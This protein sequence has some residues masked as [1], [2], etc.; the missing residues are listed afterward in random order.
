MEIFSIISK[1]PINADKKLKLFAF[2][3]RVV[4]FFK[5][6]KQTYRFFVKNQ[7]FAN[8]NHYYGH[9]YWLK[10]YSG[11]TDKIYAMIEHGVY[12]GD[13]RSLVCP[14]EEW[15]LGSVITYGDSRIK[16]L[17]ELHPD[18]NVY[19]IGPRIHYAETDRDYYNELYSQ[20]DHTGRVITI[21]PDHSLAS[22]K[23]LYDSGLFLKQADE[24][25][26][27]I[28]AKT[29][30][31]SLHPSDFLH[32][33]DLE[34]KGRK[35]IIVSG[36]NKPYKFLPRLRAIFELSDLTFSNAL[37]THVG[38]SVYMETPHVMNLESNKNI[39][40]NIIFE[41]EQNE[42]AATF[43]GNNPLQITDAQRKLCDKYFGYSHIK[44]SKQLYDILDE[45]ENK[46]KSIYYN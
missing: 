30:M 37:G 31:V 13:N 25:A 26:D 6:D 16:L 24:L 22:E 43:N 28:E 23:S 10:K 1:L 41:K 4:W 14:K 36:G 40:P 34:F 11:Y 21:F 2:V 15:S 8:S 17:E 7:V 9:E 33:L 32:H 42:F 44:T 3:K 18:M 20:I 12:F 39:R 27:K 5:Y 38:Y 29:I 19:A 46:Y 45:C 35:V